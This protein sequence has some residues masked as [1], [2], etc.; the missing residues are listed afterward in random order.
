MDVEKKVDSLL[1]GKEV[2]GWKPKKGRR[3]QKKTL[4]T[5]VALVI[6]ASV[7]IASAAVLD[8]YYK[9]TQEVTVE[10]YLMIDG[11][12]I[13]WEESVSSETVKMG[14]YLFSCHQL[15]ALDDVSFKLVSSDI[16]GIDTVWYTAKLET[17]KA[18]GA[19]FTPIAEW[20][21]GQVE[22]GDK[23]VHLVTGSTTGIGNEARAVI[24]ICSLTLDDI[25]EISWREYNVKGYPPHLDLF[26]DTDDDGEA[27]DALVFEY[28]Y[29]WGPGYH[30]DE[31]WP[32]YNALIGCWYD[33]F[34]D[35]GEGPAHIDSLSQ[36]WLSSGA[37][38]PY[39]DVCHTLEAWRNGSINPCIGGDTPIVRLEFEIDSWIAD[40][41][42][43]IDEISI[44]GKVHH[45]EELP[46]E[47]VTYIMEEGEDLYFILEHFF[48]CAPGTHTLVTEIVPVE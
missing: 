2:D 6:G 46:D 5:I 1:V 44:N 27:D 14:D 37:P 28:A 26:I 38:G 3:I 36:C 45:L 8:F 13:P 42:A 12:Y 10:G 18:D 43:Y 47:G 21:D 32:N 35:D 15:E 22:D 48:D 11:E 7:I 20:S 16:E 33:T 40:S 19:S 41:E 4:F 39:A 24:P 25:I 29:N 23:S 30:L 17:T 34:G 31:G 9:R